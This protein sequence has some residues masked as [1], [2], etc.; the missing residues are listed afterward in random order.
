MWNVRNHVFRLVEGRT[1]TPI[2]SARDLSLKFVQ[3]HFFIYSLALFA[4]LAAERSMAYVVT[5][6]HELN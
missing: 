5:R 6:K 4:S 2:T 3:L 1:R